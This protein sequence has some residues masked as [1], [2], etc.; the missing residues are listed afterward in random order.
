[1]HRHPRR[2][3]RNIGLTHPLGDV[4]AIEHHP[5]SAQSRLNFYPRFVSKFGERSL[6]V[7]RYVVL[8]SFQCQRTIHGP[9]LKIRVPEFA[10]QPGS[11]GAL[12]GSSRAVNG[13]DESASGVVA[14]LSG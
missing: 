7:E 14:H 10:S 12:A 6:I 8:D 11:D 13:N 1:M 2:S 5:V 4:P 3:L 9:T